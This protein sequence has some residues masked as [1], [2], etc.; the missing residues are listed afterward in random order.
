MMGFLA[1]NEKATLI[2]HVRTQNADTY[3][4]HILNAISWYE[5]EAVDVSRDGAKPVNVCKVRIPAALI[6][7][8]PA[9]M[10]Q[11]LDFMVHGECGGIEK[12]SD[13]QGLPY[14]QITAVSD[15]R[16]GHLPHVAVSGV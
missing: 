12:A 9:A 8:N 6:D 10:P 11:K 2:H 4:C 3:V 15:N 14:F 16:R 13:L 7:E 5:K 1:C